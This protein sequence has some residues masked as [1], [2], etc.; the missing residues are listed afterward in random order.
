MSDRLPLYVSVEDCRFGPRYMEILAGCGYDGFK[1][2]DQSQVPQSD[3]MTAGP[4]R[5]VRRV[6]S[7]TR[8]RANG[9]RMRR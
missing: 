7:A 6:R 2:L 9:C 4:L 3:R 5:P 8:C 1:L